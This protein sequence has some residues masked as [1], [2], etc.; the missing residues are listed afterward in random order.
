MKIRDRL[1]L[2]AVLCCFSALLLLPEV[3]AQAARDAMLLCAQ[4]LIP[5]LF[6]F[7]VLSSLLIACGASE[8]L[9]ALLSPL[10]RPLFGLSGT[11]A[12]ALALGLCGGYPVG[13]RTAAELVENGA[14]SQEE[15]ERL[16]AFCNNAGP[17][18]LLGVCGAGVF[19]SSRAGAALYLIHVAAALCAGLLTCRALPPVPHGTYPHK[20][21][22]AQHLSTAFPAAVQ[23]ALTGCLNVSAFV[24]FFTVLARLL[25][26]FLPEAFASSLPCALLLGFLVLT[27]GVVSLPCSRAGFLACAALLGWGGMSVHCQTLSVLAATPLSARYYLKGKV[28]QALLSLLLALPPRCRFCFPDAHGSAPVMALATCETTSATAS[29]KRCI[30][31]A[32]VTDVE[33]CPSAFEMLNIGTFYLLATLAKLWRSLWSE[34]GGRPCAAM[35]CAMRWH[36]TSG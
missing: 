7:F 28:L 34:I 25:L 20:S 13:A 6:P 17:G 33:L 29:S 9:S 14:L 11:G 23:N 24:V 2:L 35:N 18:F 36:R 3:S 30:Y 16:L 31:T 26:H 15:G 8:L 21:A 5:S 1:P 22:K 27:S 10:M 4:T 12:A 32:L 19:S